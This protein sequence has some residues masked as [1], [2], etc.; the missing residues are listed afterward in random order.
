MSTDTQ[1]LLSHTSAAGKASIIDAHIIR[2]GDLFVVSDQRGNIDPHDAEKGM[3]VYH[4]DMRYL[5]GWSFTLDGV[6][7]Q[8]LA[9]DATSCFASDI[10]LTNLRADELDEHVLRMRLTRTIA[11]DGSCFID[12]IDLHDFGTEPV[13]LSLVCRFAPAFDSIFEVRSMVGRELAPPPQIDAPKIDDKTIRWTCTGRDDTRRA[14]SIAFD[15]APDEITEHDATFTLSLVPGETGGRRIAIVVEIEPAEDM[16]DDHGGSTSSDRPSDVPAERTVSGHARAR[17]R[18]DEMQQ[19]AE[20]ERRAWVGKFCTLRTES[21]LLANL[22][23]QAIAD[24][25][26]LLSRIEGRHYLAAGTPWFATLFGRDSMIAAW[27]SMLHQ[28]RIAADTLRLL[29]ATQGTGV[30][31]T[32]L[33]QPGHII[34]EIRRDDLTRAGLLPYGPFYGAIDTTAL[35]VMLLGRHARHTGSLDLFHE[36]R[37]HVDAAIDW[38]ER[39]LDGDGPMRGWVAYDGEVHDGTMVQQGW[40]DSGNSVIGADGSLS[41]PPIA[42]VEV[43]AYAWSALTECA[44]LHER[45]GEHG[46]AERLRVRAADLRERFI[47]R[48]WSDRIDMLGL[49]LHGP[50]AAIVPVASSNPGHALF[51]HGLLDALPARAVADRLMRDDLF[52]GWGIRTLATSERRYNPVGYHLGSVW[53]HDNAIIA[54]GFR[55]HGFDDH[56]QRL[57]DGLL[58]A[59]SE[60]GDH[61]LPELFAGDVREVPAPPVKYPVAC[62]PQAWASGAIL[63]VLTTMLGVDIDGFARRLTVRAP[64]LPAFVDQLELHD[65]DVCGTPISLRFWR[66]IDEAA[67]GRTGRSVTASKLA[68]VH[69]R[70]LSGDPSIDVVIE[71]AADQG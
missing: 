66:E 32:T 36:L 46:S 59:A 5:C 60:M 19:R 39:H 71:A 68:P 8:L 63:Q 30:D 18:R 43:Q 53:P 51:T 40:K 67:L 15:H 37:M 65:V 45:A 49:A 57:C 9:D 7:M 6:P 2:N 50:R 55:R 33:E 12:L 56:A 64:L 20:D 44:D 41:S 42:L 13:T 21:H 62:H 16:R 4:G 69:C 52:S 70:V 54:E 1:G 28:P 48:F 14:V 27:F 58:T 3:G 61:R 22:Y 11:P 31:A 34:H 10:Q 35:F 26:A 47:E 25:H 17:A 23:H 24:L 29:A 38:I